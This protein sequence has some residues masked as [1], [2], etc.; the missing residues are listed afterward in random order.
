MV[1][2]NGKV[3]EIPKK[4]I[5]VGDVVILNTG[6]EI[7]AD[8]VLLEAVSLQVNESTLTGELMVNKTTDEAHFDE[9]AT[10]PSNSVMRGTT[11]TDG[12]GVMRVE[13]W[14]MRQKLV[15]WPDRLR[16]KVRSRLL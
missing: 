11:V 8:G 13:R 10:Y 6:D 16:S 1:I 4:D 5:V 2:R 14:V 3:H 12:H 15:K 9:E 7:P